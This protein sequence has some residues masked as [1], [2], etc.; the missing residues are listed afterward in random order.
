MTLAQITM[1]DV[2]IQWVIVGIVVAAAI[3][4]ALIVIRQAGIQIPGW[5]GQVGWI[6]LLAVVAIVSIK[7][8]LMLL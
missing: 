6:V 5:V 3:G 1:A 2:L 7:F 8:L 4:I